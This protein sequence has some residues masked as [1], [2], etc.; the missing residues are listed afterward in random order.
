MTYYN[1]ASTLLQVVLRNDIRSKMKLIR[2]VHLSS[3]LDKN[4]V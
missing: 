1:S 4:L 3:L 2:K